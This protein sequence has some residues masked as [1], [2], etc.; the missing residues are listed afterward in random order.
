MT[1]ANRKSVARFYI[2]VLEDMHRQPVKIEDTGDPNI[3]ALNMLDHCLYMCH[4]LLGF[5]D[6]RRIDK[7]DRWL[8]FVQGVFAA[9]CMYTI[10]EMAQHNRIGVDMAVGT[11]VVNNGI[12][13]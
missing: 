13:N 8:G 7:A 1:I 12:R 5:I 4:E 10:K 11:G 2:K 9:Y 3:P 6:Q